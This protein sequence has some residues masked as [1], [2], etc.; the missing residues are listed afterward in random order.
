[1]WMDLEGVMLRC[2]RDFSLHW[3]FVAVHRLAVAVE[4]RSSSLVMVLGLLSAVASKAL[5]FQ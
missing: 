4:S 2:Y 3:V 1:M 5:R